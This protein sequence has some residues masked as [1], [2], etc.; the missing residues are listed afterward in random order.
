MPLWLAKLSEFDHLAEIDRVAALVRQFDADRVLAGNDG[1]AGGDRRHRAGDIV[2]KADDA[3]R[4]DAGRRL[5]LIERDD[6]AGAHL[7]DLALDAEVL[8][9]AFEQP[10]VLL[11][12]LGRH[13]GI[14]PLR[15]DRRQELDRGQL[16]LDGIDDRHRLRAHRHGTAGAGAQPLLL[17]ADRRLGDDADAGIALRTLR[18]RS[19][20]ASTGRRLLRRPRVG[21]LRGFGLLGT[22]AREGDDVAGEKPAPAGGLLGGRR[23]VRRHAVGG[24]DEHFVVGRR[25]RGG[26]EAV[27]FLT[28]VPG[29]GSGLRLAPVGRVV[30]IRL[31]GGVRI[32]VVVGVRLTLADRIDITLFGR[33]HGDADRPLDRPRRRRCEVLGLVLPIVEAVAEL[34]GT[35]GGAALL[36][37]ALP[38]R[39]GR[40]DGMGDGA[41]D[42]VELVLAFVLLVDRTAAHGLAAPHLGLGDGTIAVDQAGTVEEQPGRGSGEH[43][44]QHH[45]E[46]A[47]RIGAGGERRELQDDV[48][49][50]AAEADRQRPGLGRGEAA[51]RRAGEHDAADRVP[52]PSP[53]ALDRAAGEQREAPDRRERDQQRG[54]DAEDLHQEIRD[55]GAR[56]ARPVLHHVLIGLAQRGIRHRPRRAGEAEI[57]RKADQ[58]RRRTDFT[59]PANERDLP[60]ACDR[61]CH[62]PDPYFWRSPNST[63]ALV[64]RDPIGGGLRLA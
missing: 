61:R 19:L 10:G 4:L 64:A 3:G 1:D 34:A 43:D 57:A 62:L 15:L 60:F 52:A 45:G 16:E 29:F 32:G 11:Q 47:A 39:L 35:L 20:G 38:G 26:I 9:H 58:R 5:Q 55:D 53:D 13:G 2:G 46:H 37:M 40:I 24:A 48:A 63:D 25:P 51:D 14:A 17:G 44:G 6:G 27:L 18:L 41:D 22:A 7:D 8:E 59:L 30:E 31:F 36:G 49:G 28:C 42:E 50:D 23:D 54:A 21:P 56:G 33:R 12:G